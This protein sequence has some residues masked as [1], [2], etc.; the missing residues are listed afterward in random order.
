MKVRL[1]PKCQRAKNRVKEHGRVMIVKQVGQLHT[2]KDCILVESI[3]LS[4]MLKPGIKQHW[5][6]WF[7]RDEADWEFIDG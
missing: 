7:T 5:V 4:W 3:G 6:G 1:T 2:N